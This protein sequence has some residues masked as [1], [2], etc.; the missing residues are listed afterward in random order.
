MGRVY[1][2]VKDRLNEIDKWINNRFE[3][4]IQEHRKFEVK[5]LNAFC[6]NKP[7][8]IC[9]R[10]V[11][12]RRPS[13]T[14]WKDIDTNCEIDNLIFNEDRFYFIECKCFGKRFW[15]NGQELYHN[16]KPYKKYRYQLTKQMTF[17][18]ETDNEKLDKILKRHFPNLDTQNILQF[19]N[20]CVPILIV[21]QPILVPNENLQLGTKNRI[22]HKII[23]NKIPI[24]S[25]QYLLGGG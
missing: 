10:N 17:F 3:K 24:M 5:V 15:T 6:K 16:G 2:S 12:I 20:N 19:K 25:Y 7:K 21:N 18:K 23:L 22:I 4:E 8:A 13:E 9:F 14:K 11:I 1:P